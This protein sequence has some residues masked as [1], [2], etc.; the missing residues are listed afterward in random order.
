MKRASTI[1]TAGVLLAGAVAALALVP[2]EQ[3]Q[4]AD[5]L[6]KR[7]MYDVAIREYLQFLAATNAPQADVVYYR[8][9]E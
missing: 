1:F 8:I 4:F 5:G 9:G 7:G 3:L 2:D 6:Y